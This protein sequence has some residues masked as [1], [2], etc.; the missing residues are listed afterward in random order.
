MAMKIYAT[1]CTWF[2]RGYGSTIVPRLKE[3]KKKRL[4]FASGCVHFSFHPKTA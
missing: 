2:L 3:E 1:Y 4:R